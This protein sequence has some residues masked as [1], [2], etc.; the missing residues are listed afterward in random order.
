MRAVVTFVL[1][2]SIVVSSG[3]KK[4]SPSP[5]NKALLTAPANNE[6]CAPISSS[7]DENNTVRFTWQAADNTDSYQLH[8]RNL[9]TNN[10][11]TR[12][13]EVTGESVSLPK[14]TPFSWFVITENRQTADKV[15]SDTWRFYNPGSETARIPFPAEIISPRSGASVV[16]DMNNE[17][18]LQWEGSDIDG[19]IESFEIYLST[20]NPPETLIETLGANA[21]SQPVS[22]DA[23]TIYYWRIVTRDTEGNTSDTGTLD[24]K[25]L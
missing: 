6:E 10:A 11:I 15:M 21:N 5:P 12:N 13:L 4:D 7:S 14:G 3:C 24:F 17:I 2:I 19:D 20:E 23:D 16:R 1:I 25:V 8:I 18:M 9:V 22:V